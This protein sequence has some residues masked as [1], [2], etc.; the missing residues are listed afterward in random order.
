MQFVGRKYHD[1]A[2]S[3]RLDLTFDPYLGLTVDQVEELGDRMLVSF[4]G[5]AGLKER[6][7]GAKLCLRWPGFRKNLCKASDIYRVLRLV[8]VSRLRFV[9]HVTRF[10]RRSIS[11]QRF[12]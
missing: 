5:F 8:T 1:I 9:E 2:F 3:Q 10:P 7:S 4:N 11:N 6:H 12:R